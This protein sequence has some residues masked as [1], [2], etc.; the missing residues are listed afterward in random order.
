MDWWAAVILNVRFK[1]PFVVLWSSCSSSLWFTQTHKHTVSEAAQTASGHAIAVITCRCVD[2]A[3]CMQ[4]NTSTSAQLET[5][6][7]CNVYEDVGIL[8]RHAAGWLWIHVMLRW[9]LD[10]FFSDG[11]F[12]CRQTLAS[13]WKPLD[14]RKM[15]FQSTLKCGCGPSCVE[16]L[17]VLYLCV[18]IYLL[19]VLFCLVMTVLLTTDTSII[20]V[21]IDLLLI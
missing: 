18:F 21:Y 14:G 16:E 11:N 7:W 4:T 5:T 3:L 15:C 20:F 17:H 1:T 10:F 13:G 12:C 2:G 6:N 19:L 8:S 9:H